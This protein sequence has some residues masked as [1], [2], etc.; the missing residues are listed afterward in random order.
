MLSAFGGKFSVTMRV[1]PAEYRCGR[2]VQS[3]LD[4]DWEQVVW[5]DADWG[6]EKNG[7]TRASIRV[8]AGDVVFLDRDRNVVEDHAMICVRHISAR[9]VVHLLW[10]AS[11]IDAGDSPVDGRTA[12]SA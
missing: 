3:P 8:G 11:C 4:G 5:G 2:P 6:R 7:W 12:Y 1:F 10:N 9:Y